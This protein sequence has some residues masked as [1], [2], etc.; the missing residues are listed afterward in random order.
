MKKLMLQLVK[1]GGVG[2]LCFLID[3]AI[4]S[5]LTEAFKVNYLVSSA[6]AF[7]V[8]VVVNYVL[9]VVFVFDVDCQNNKKR[10][11]ILFVF[12]S[13]IGLILTELI[14]KLG[15]DIISWDYRVV[16]IAA[17]AIIMIYNFVTRK[18]FLE[19]KGNKN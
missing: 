5:L 10:N 19:K 4:L 3:F 14:M 2:F 13:V 16:K 15:V 9:S 8:S 1:F 11:F 6:I 17:T 18:L 12:F 7:S